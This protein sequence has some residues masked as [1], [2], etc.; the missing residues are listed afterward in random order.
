MGQA[1]INVCKFHDCDIFV[2]V[3]NEEKKKF[4]MDEYNIPENRIFSSRDIHF[5][6]KIK[7]LTEGKGVDIVLNSLA[8]DKLEASYECVADCG[9]FVEIG[10]YDLQMNKQL[11]MFSFLR[12]ISFIGVAMDQK[13]FLS[14]LFIEKFFDWMHNNSKNGMIRPINRTIFRAEEAENAFRYMT[15]GKH[16]GKIVIKIRDKEKEEIFTEIQSAKTLTTIAKTYFDG[17]KVYIISGGLGGFGL[18]LLHWMLFLGARKFVLTSRHGV[19]TDYQRFLLKRLEYLSEKF[20]IFKTEIVV[21]TEVCSTM[22]ST[23]SLVKRSQQL[24]TIGGVFHLALVLND[25]LLEN[26]TL[27]NFKETIDSK[28]N[29]FKNLDQLSRDLRLDFDYFVVFSSVSCGKGNVGQTNYGFGNS[30]CERICED[31]RRDGLQGLAI[32]WGPIGDVGVAA[33]T[34]IPSFVGISKQRINSCLDVLDKLLGVSDAIVSCIV[35]TIAIM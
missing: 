14:D 15:T 32:Q 1:A 35:R 12:D 10:K 6:Y 7:A 24:G 2:T 34:E 11:G 13:L 29:A 23:R 16:I 5:K 27:D 20:R 33:D 30:V 25:C 21:T 26:Q 9:R 28:I 8:G 4:L 3:G 22:E 17:N 19:K 31:R 18:E